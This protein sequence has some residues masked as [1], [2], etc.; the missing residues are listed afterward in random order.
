M[1]LSLWLIG[2]YIVAL[3]A[4]PAD[5]GPR[6]GGVV[7]SAARLVLLAAIVV[8]LIDWRGHLHAARTVPRAVWMGWLAFLGS[9]LVTAALFPSF[10][11]WARYGSLILEGVAV[12]LLVYRA[13]LDP[14]GLR[15]LVAV[16]AATTVAIAGVVL[17]LAAFG[18]HYDQI[19]AGIAG[20]EPIPESLPRFGLE[21]QAGSFRAALFFGIWLAVAS[22]LLLPWMAEG[23]RRSRWIARAAWVLLLAAVTLLTTS[24]LAITA[25]FVLPGVYFLARGRRA[26][27]AA[28]LLLGAIV[29]V[30]LSAL[31]LDPQAGTGGLPDTTPCGWTPSGRRS[32]RFARTRCL[33]GDC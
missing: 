31:T 21:R 10:A 1:P 23:A 3:I 2:L 6:I 28:F 13:S 5:F 17:A 7:L 18:Q 27:G 8:A 32:R 11:S 9:T 16:T 26:T 12:F 14:N 33:A 24:R 30:A 19:L 25:M 29:A 15:T 20:T 4:F 22:V